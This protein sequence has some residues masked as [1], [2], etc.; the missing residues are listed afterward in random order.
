MV[1]WMFI[2]ALVLGGAESGF[3]QEPPC[4]IPRQDLVDVVVRAAVTR[5]PAGFDYHYAVTNKP[6]AQQ[7]LVSFA[8]ETVGTSVPAQTSPPRWESG[9]PIAA[10]SFLVWDTFVDPRGLAPGSSAEGFGFSDAALPAVV[11]FLAWG[12][13]ELPRHPEGEAPNS[14]GHS[15]VIQNS[16]KGATIGPRTPPAVFVSPEFLNYIISLLHDRARS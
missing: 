4:E 5:S 12:D 10:S 6:Q 9:G 1:K 8:I 11:E 13:V 2:A 15:D 3:A 7:T 16:F 14:C